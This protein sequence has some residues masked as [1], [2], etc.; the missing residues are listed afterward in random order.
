VGLFD[1]V[2]DPKRAFPVPEPIAMYTRMILRGLS[3]SA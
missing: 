1:A 2:L 3:A